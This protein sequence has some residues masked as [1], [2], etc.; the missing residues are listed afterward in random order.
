MRILL[1]RTDRMG[2]LILS[3]PA[4]ATVRKSYPCAHITMVCSPYNAVVMERNTDVDEVLLLPREVKPAAF[5][6][7][8]R[9]F[10]IAVALAPRSQDLA[11][12]GATRARVRVGYTYGRRYLMRAT[13]WF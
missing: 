9:D 7:N 3:T 5:G 12:V 4:I 8:F 10:D 11:L 2:D 13:A 1:S 6:K